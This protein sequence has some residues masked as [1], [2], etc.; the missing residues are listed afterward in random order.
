MENLVWLHLSDIHYCY[1]NY[2]TK[3]M[4]SK[5]VEVIK[6]INK[7]SDIKFIFITGDLLY[8]FRNDFSSVSEFI[9]DI[10]KSVNLEKDKVLIVPGNHDLRRIPL[11]KTIIDGLNNSGEIVCKFVSNMD[12]DT[13]RILL[14][15][16]KEFFNFYKEFLE[17]DEKWD[18][19]HFYKEYGECNIINLNTCLLSGQDNEEGK[20]SIDLDKLIDVLEN[21]KDSDKPNIVMGHHS[22]ECFDES[23][24]EQIIQMFDDYGV[25]LYLCGHVHKS[26]YKIHNDSKRDIPCLV[27]GSA[28]VDDYSDPSFIIGEINMESFLCSVKYY[29]WNNRLNLWSED[30][31]VSRKIIDNDG[32][33]FYLT[34]LNNKKEEYFKKKID[35]F[36]NVNISTSKFRKFILD[37]CKN[38][39][40]DNYNNES[41]REKDVEDKFEKM[42]CSESFQFDFDANVEYFSIIDNIFSDPSYVSYD[43]KTLIPGVIRSVYRKSLN[44]CNNGDDI[45]DSMVYLLCNEY[46]KETNIPRLELEQYFRTIIYWSINICT[47]YNDRK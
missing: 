25:D 43:R 17:R 1:N 42:K 30:N 15:G 18:E 36:T 24:R 16:Q 21:I 10:I 7:K 39:E 5:L 47:I 37:F 33:K 6:D 12:R 22:I 32:I 27:C 40:K 35:N 4:R 11:R 38:I 19:L 34:R 3:W 20:L 14:E 41:S 13:Y 44:L 9:E 26:K 23:E 31:N 46:E 2:N 28:M 45:M 8:Q 29:V